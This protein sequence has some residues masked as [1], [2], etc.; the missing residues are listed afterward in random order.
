LRQ[1][2]VDSQEYPLSKYVFAV[3]AV[4]GACCTFSAA[5]APAGSGGSTARG[6]STTATAPATLP[7]LPAEEIKAREATARA[8]LKGFFQGM[9]GGDEKAAFALV[10][11][12]DVDEAGQPKSKEKAETMLGEV[13]AEQRLRKAVGAAFGNAEFKLGRGDADVAAFNKDFET[14]RTTVAPDGTS[15]TVAMPLGISYVLIWKD[16]KWLVDFDKTQ[17][18]IG[19][20]PRDADLGSLTRMTEG[21]DQLAKDVAAK[22]FGK[23]EEVTKEAERIAKAA[24]TV[25]AVETLPAATTTKPATRP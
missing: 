14:A 25:T 7:A 2:T 3:A 24:A 19:P 18:G 10:A 4:I 1:M 17:L 20:L 5:A 21:Y 6:P 23:V 12:T 8:V 13:A 16:G 11:Y 9:F 22:K 15:A